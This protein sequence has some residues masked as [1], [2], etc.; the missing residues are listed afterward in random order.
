MVESGILNA[1]YPEIKNGAFLGIIGRGQGGSVA[2]SI[3]TGYI[4]YI[5]S[6]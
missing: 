1:G 2:S 5:W 4:E 6:N 3:L